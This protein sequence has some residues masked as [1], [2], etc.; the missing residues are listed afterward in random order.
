M[1]KV[2]G[3]VFLNLTLADPLKARLKNTHRPFEQLV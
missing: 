1:S 2:A 3:A